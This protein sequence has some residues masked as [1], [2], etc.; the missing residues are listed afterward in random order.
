MKILNSLKI[1][2][3]ISILALLIILLVLSWK[4]QNIMNYESKFHN[5][6]N[7]MLNENSITTYNIPQ[8]IKSNIFNGKITVL[9]IYNI[10]NINHLLNLKF[11][12]EIK[13]HIK[14]EDINVINIILDNSN[15]LLDDK[16]DELINNKNEVFIKKNKID[17]PVL[18]L[19]DEI[20]EKYF[21]LKNIDN[22]IIILD[23][24][25]NIN[26][27]ENNNTDINI[28]VDKITNISR[29]SKMIY[30]K[31][32]DG[33]GLYS[34]KSIKN[35]DFIKNFKKFIIIE[36]FRGY[37]F[38]LFA[39][40]DD[41]NNTI[42]I[43]KI[44][45][46]ILYTI[47]NKNFCKL[48]NIKYVNDNL[49]VSDVCNN[50]IYKIDFEN[51]NF[52]VFIQSEELFGISDF[53]LVN[54]TEMLISKYKKNGI[55]VFNLKTK[56]YTSLIDYLKL[57]YSIGLVNKIIRYKNII[58]YFDVNNYVL[59]SYD[60]NSKTNSVILD[61]NKYDNINIRDEGFDV[62][63]ISSTSNIYFMNV[64]NRNILHF[65]S[66]NLQEQYFK[67]FK[68]FPKDLIMYKNIY[69]FLFDDNIQIVNIYNSKMYNLE[70]HFSN[71]RQSF[72]NINNL[73][74]YEVDTNRFTFKGELIETNN[75]TKNINILP[76]SPSYLII[77][78][79]KDNNLIPIKVFYYNSLMNGDSFKIEK[80]KQYLIYGDLYY[81]DENNKI[82][83]FN[84][85][86]S[87][88]K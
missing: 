66:G 5:N 59:Y 10:N 68:S 76:Y 19:S 77:F 65:N 53:E 71:N 30:N 78:E 51:Q 16:I 13:Q 58:Y 12:K 14:T 9:N 55:G 52:E 29:K 79:K 24:I 69:Y 3:R 25:G 64:N 47:N 33:N 88:N 2:L 28:L 50:S 67:N 4:K 23:E 73:Y 41:I 61:L 62:F 45:G 32:L 18:V 54:D 44:N 11:N 70:L 60:N 84:I 37:S 75:I 86:F 7:T 72:F 38:P 46:D 80:N 22:K 21:N 57:D 8:N 48:S 56:K 63:Y 20:F 6:F 39:I 85:N 31:N 87:F 27:I 17:D 49:Y 35:N 82:K 81:N 36:N 40:I 1:I 26:Y 83:V 34:S 42:L 43:T 74:I 15:N